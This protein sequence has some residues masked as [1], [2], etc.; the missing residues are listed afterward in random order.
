MRTYSI[1]LTKART[2][3]EIHAIIKATL[4][5]P[6]WYG[7]NLDALWDLLTGHIGPCAIQIK[8]PRGASPE[9]MQYA[10][11]TIDVFLRAEAYYREIEVTVIHS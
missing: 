3:G 4:H 2:I 11:K 10:Q 1:D 5:F 9:I 8:R 7:E 6:E